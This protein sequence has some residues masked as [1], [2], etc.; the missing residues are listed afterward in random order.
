MTQVMNS[1][2]PSV[3]D[4]ILK[5]LYSAPG[6]SGP[7]ERDLLRPVGRSVRSFLLRARSFRFFS[8]AASSSSESESFGE[9]SESESS[10][11][12]AF[13]AFCFCFYFYFCFLYSRRCRC[14][15]LNRNR[16]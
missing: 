5:F 11:V 2:T 4:A 8:S 1:K 13:F 15:C 7:L 12:A 9:S 16:L 14:H 6:L 10:F 3:N